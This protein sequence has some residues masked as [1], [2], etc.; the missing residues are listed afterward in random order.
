MR[1]D[2]TQLLDP[3]GVCLWAE[4]VRSET[5]FEKLRASEFAMPTLSVALEMLGMDD[6]E[7][8]AAAREVHAWREDQ[9][10]VTVRGDV[11]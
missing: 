5:A 9:D 10:G 6:A 8:A 4:G 2:Y 11:V 3:R 7:A 1:E